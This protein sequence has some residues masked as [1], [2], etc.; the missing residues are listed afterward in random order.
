MKKILFLLILLFSVTSVVGQSEKIN[1]SVID[2]FI[3]KKSVFEEK[4]KTSQKKAFGFEL[5]DYNEMHTRVSKIQS[6][7]LEKLVKDNRFNLV[8]R[9]KINI[10]QK[11]REL[12][13]SMD[14]IDGYVTN[15]GKAV[16][17]DYL[18]L[19][20]FELNEMSFTISIYSVADEKLVASEITMLKKRL[21]TNFKS[22]RTPI[23]EAT[24]RLINKLAPNYMALLEVTNER[25]GSAK[26]V[27]IAGGTGRG[28]EKGDE[29]EFKIIEE[30]T[31][32]GEILTYYK[33]IGTG[34]IDKIEGKNFSLIS[35]KKGGKKIAT[36]IQSGQKIVCSKK[37]K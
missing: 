27:L 17:A 20:D 6:Y 14:F 7:V 32:E 9:S 19:G 23:D 5:R 21:S 30:R 12:Q 13:K 26:E 3:P 36:L 35:I 31:V 33:T 28:L 37:I 24:D 1:C 22:I 29:V 18:I 11:E 10:I 25:K 34:E 8:E 2:F 4:G 15:Q 16:G